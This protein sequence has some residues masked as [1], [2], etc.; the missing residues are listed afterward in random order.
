LDS[1]KPNILKKI[2]RLW[3]LGFSLSLDETLKS[4]FHV[5]AGW[6]TLFLGNL[7]M[8]FETVVLVPKLEFGNEKYV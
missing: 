6:H 3:N 8:T 7:S 2:A 1:G 5:L 4:E